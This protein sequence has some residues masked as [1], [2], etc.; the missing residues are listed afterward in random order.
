MIDGADGTN[1]QMEHTGHKT[2]RIFKPFI[3]SHNLG[4][5]C[6]LCYFIPNTTN[7]RNPSCHCLNNFT[8]RSSSSSYDN[9]TNPPRKSKL[10]QTRAKDKQKTSSAGAGLLHRMQGKPYY[11][12]FTCAPLHIA[13]AGNTLNRFIPTHS[14]TGCLRKLL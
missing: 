1:G 10:F 12:F 6:P 5:L 11:T 4:S 13:E 9:P 8:K 2:S 7:S 14:P 3:A